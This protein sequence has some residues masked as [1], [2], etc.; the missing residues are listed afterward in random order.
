MQETLVQFLHWEDSLEKGQATHS[1][2]LGPPWQLRW[3]RIL[4]HCWRPGVD[5]WVGKIPQRRKWQLTPVVLP[6]EFHGQ[7]CPAGYSPWGCKQLDTTERLS[8]YLSGVLFLVK[9]MLSVKYAIHKFFL[10][11]KISYGRYCWKSNRLIPVERW[12]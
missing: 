9:K 8:L 7:R 12:A 2:I 4:L 5:S 10:H 11:I 1:S 3:Q 6:G